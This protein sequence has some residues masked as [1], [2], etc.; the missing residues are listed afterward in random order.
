MS[1]M[2]AVLGVVA[3]L[4]VGA[5]SPGPSF[6]MVARSAASVGRKQG[7][8]AALGMGV[9]GMLFAIASLMGLS[10]LFQAVP[11]LYI[12]LKIIGGIYLAYL[13]LKIWKGAR[14]PLSVSEESFAH[15]SNK[16][17]HFLIGLTTQLSNPKTAIVYASVFATFLPNTISFQYGLLIAVLVFC[18][19][20]GWYTLVA[21]VLSAESPRQ[22]YLKY[23]HWV[24]RVAGGVMGVLGIK[25]AV[26]AIK[27]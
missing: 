19:E 3:A 25:L 4:A 11:I 20:A 14:Q 1:E 27:S 16:Q 15:A 9:G 8:F 13:G 10:V 12:G 22:T 6:V 26:S 24:D 2:A 17:R 7:L 21:L 23:K 18:V 5:M